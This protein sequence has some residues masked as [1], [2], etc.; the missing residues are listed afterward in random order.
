MTPDERLEYRAKLSRASL[1]Q[2]EERSRLRRREWAS[3]SK[4]E[5]TAWAERPRKRGKRYWAKLTPAERQAKM[6]V[7]TAAAAARPREEHV[8][9]AMSVPRKLRVARAK[10]GWVT[11]RLRNGS[12]PDRG[13]MTRRARHAERRHEGGT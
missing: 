9:W 7:L 2:S 1:A 11:R 4:V 3:R 10:A 13:W 8:A 5:R 6:Q 12:G